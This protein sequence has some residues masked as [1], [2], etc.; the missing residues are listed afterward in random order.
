MA[1]IQLPEA[2]ASSPTIDSADTAELAI[3]GMTCASCVMRVEKKL[4][5][6]PGVSDAAVNLATERAMVTYDPA[7]IDPVSLVRAVETAGYGA[8]LQEHD[9]PLGATLAVSGMTCAACVRRVERA[10]LKVPGVETAGVNLATERAQVT[11]GGQATID[12]LL[13][14]VEQAGYHAEPVVAAT[15]E[16]DGPGGGGASSRPPR[17]AHPLRQARPRSRPDDPDPLHRHVPVWTCATAT[18]G[19]SPSPRPSGSSSAG[20]STAAPSRMPATA[21]SIWTRSSRSAARSPLSTASSLPSRGR[22]PSTTPPRSSSPSSS[23]AKSWRRWRRVGRAVRSV[24]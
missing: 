12:D 24:H 11:L 7:Q 13:T 17:D 14:A 22:I 15:A 8:T 18:T 5:K 2:A 23:S 10:L 6:V 16:R 9:E 1:T 21:R 19:C 4:K 3:T 20:T